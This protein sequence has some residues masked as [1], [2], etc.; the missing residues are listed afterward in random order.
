MAAYHWQT[1]IDFWFE[2]ISPRHW[3]QKD[4]AFDNSILSRF[5]DW[6]I[7]AKKA[8]CISGVPSLWD[9]SQK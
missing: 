6:L 4:E 2:E 3:W 5:G 9:D 7:A 1:V 8:S